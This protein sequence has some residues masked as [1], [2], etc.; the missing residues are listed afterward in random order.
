MGTHSLSVLPCRYRATPLTI[1]LGQAGRAGGL[2][3]RQ[4]VELI[5]IV[6]NDCVPLDLRVL[7]QP[8]ADLIPAGALWQI[9]DNVCI[10]DAPVARA[11]QASGVVAPIR[12]ENDLCTG[13]EHQ[14]P[15][16][17]Q[18][19]SVHDIGQV[20]WIGRFG[21]IEDPVDVEKNNPH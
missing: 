6:V 4:I 13:P 17:A 9:R 21:A 18:K 20:P 10:S 19:P 7:S 16:C 1:F 15:E 11:E 3:K 14:L 5:V 2:E 8:G 12:N